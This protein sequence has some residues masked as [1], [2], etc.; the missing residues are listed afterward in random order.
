MSVLHVYACQIPPPR[1][2]TLPL[3]TTRAFTAPPTGLHSASCAAAGALERHGRALESLNARCS[4]AAKHVDALRLD[5]FGRDG[6]AA[7]AAAAGAAGGGGDL[8]GGGGCACDDQEESGAAAPLA[9]RMARAE[10]AWRRAAAALEG[11]AD[12]AA[13]RRALLRLDELQ[14]R[15][16]LGGRTLYQCASLSCWAAALQLL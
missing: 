4:S 1:M 7:A 11:K 13:L 10:A 15:V 2:Y 14:E 8:G 3:K 6:C 9:A 16:C 5:V 12:G